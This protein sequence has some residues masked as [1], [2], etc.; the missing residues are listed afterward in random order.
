MIWTQSIAPWGLAIVAI[1]KFGRGE[2]GSSVFFLLL[3]IL[4]ELNSIRIRIY[5]PKDDV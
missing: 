3:A 1:Y 2:I 4:D 5:R